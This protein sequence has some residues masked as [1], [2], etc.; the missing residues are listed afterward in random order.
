MSRQNRTAQWFVILVLVGSVVTGAVCMVRID[1]L[2]AKTAK[3]HLTTKQLSRA[4]E[5]YINSP[6]SS[7]P[8][9]PTSL[10][11][12]LTPP[13]HQQ[14][15]LRNGVEDLIDPWG[16]PYELEIMTGPDD[17]ERWLVKTTA[18]DGTPI[19]QFGIGEAAKPK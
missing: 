19:S 6:C 5:M 9:F 7:A 12:L 3:A 13:C 18:P 4:I 15:L 11:D 2:D 10:N 14:S 17:T 1:R 16:K 8:G